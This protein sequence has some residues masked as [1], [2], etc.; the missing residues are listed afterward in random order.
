MA[1]MTMMMTMATTTMIMMTMATTTMM[2][3]TKTL[4]LRVE[5]ARRLSSDGGG[6]GLDVSYE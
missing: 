3:M 1:T 5:K 6:N 4:N 2:M